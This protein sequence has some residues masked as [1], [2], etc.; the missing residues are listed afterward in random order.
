MRPFSKNLKQ[1]T[2]IDSLQTDEEGFKGH[3]LS[4]GWATMPFTDGTR[5]HLG[6]LFYLTLKL[7]VIKYFYITQ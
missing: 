2:L 6:I 3:S 5:Y 1:I 4:T 7:Y